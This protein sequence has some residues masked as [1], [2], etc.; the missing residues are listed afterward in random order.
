MLHITHT[1]THPPPAF[2]GAEPLH[3]LCRGPLLTLPRALIL[4]MPYC[5]V[6][7]AIRWTSS[8]L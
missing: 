4:L 3:A 5:R 8:A 6:M 7:L 2:L 1:H